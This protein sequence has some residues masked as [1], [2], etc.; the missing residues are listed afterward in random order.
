MKMKLTGGLGLLLATALATGEA[1]PE[2]RVTL[3]T[4]PEE[5]NVPIF[6][7]KEGLHLGQTRLEPWPYAVPD[8][9][10]C[11]LT[12]E[13]DFSPVGPDRT[14]ILA[15]PGAA[16][17]TWFFADRLRLPASLPGGAVLRA[18]AGPELGLEAG[19]ERAT[20]SVGEPRWLEGCQYHLIWYDQPTSSAAS[21]GGTTQNPEAAALAPQP[22]I[23]AEDPS[24]HVQVQGQ[25]R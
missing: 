20:L 2:T 7:S 3:V 12:L 15:A 24:H 11:S 1:L 19:S 16:Q 4:G 18:Q 25:C 23:I 5:T 8:C 13:R 22:E 10:G 17:P 14:L 21:G 9:D 6:T